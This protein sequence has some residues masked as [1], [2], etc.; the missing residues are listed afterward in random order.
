MRCELSYL[1]G[2]KLK[3]SKVTE[4]YRCCDRACSGEW[5]GLRR[6]DYFLRSHVMRKGEEL[7]RRDLLRRAA[8]TH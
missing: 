4:G 7:G 5:C 8:K 3:F 6:L 2:T 1:R